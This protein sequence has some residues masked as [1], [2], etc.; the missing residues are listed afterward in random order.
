MVLL[1]SLL[2]A[3]GPAAPG[4]AW[5]ADPPAAPPAAAPAP[6]Q[7]AVA[8]LPVPTPALAAA[9]AAGLPPGTVLVPLPAPAAAALARDPACRSRPACLAALLPPGV[10]HAVDLRLQGSGAAAAVD[11]RLLVGGR[12]STRRAVFVTPATLAETVTTEVGAMLRPHQP[13][14]QAYLRHDRG[15]AAAAETLRRAFPESPWTQALGL[16]PADA[17]APAAPD[18]DAP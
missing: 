11:L 16:A 2:L 18:P 7:L 9:A 10:D 8:L 5:A 13:D 15:D 14:A 4:A 1:I 6:D 12:L 17:P 3:L